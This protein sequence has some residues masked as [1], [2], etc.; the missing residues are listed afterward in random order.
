[1]SWIKDNKFLVGLGGGTLAGVAVLYFVGSSGAKN[2]DKALEDFTNASGEVESILRLPLSPTT[3][4]RDG[5]TKALDD[6][7][8]AVESIQTAFDA[9][10]PKEIK[11][12]SPEEFTNRIKAAN[13]EVRAGFDQAGSKVP[14][15]FLFC[16]FERYKDTLAPGNATGILDYQ[17]GGV[18]SVMLALAKSGI[19]E[20]RNV[21]RPVLP[22]EEG[23]E[24]KAGDSDVARPLPLEITFQGSE[25]SVRNFMSALSKLDG[26]YAVIRSIRVSNAKKDPPRTADAKFDKPAAAKP[27]AGA[28]G[29]VFGGGFVLPGDEPAAPAP[30]P[31][32]TP[33]PAPAPKADSSRILAQVLG[34]EDVQVFIRLDLLQF[35]PA[36]KLP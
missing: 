14:D 18:K 29:D 30:A 19:T 20:L 1:M 36:K 24:Y 9:Y 11:N 8:K 35:L 21:H 22:E 26:H 31:A 3:P 33:A 7:R 32:P 17:L 27:A 4:N 28:T 2:Y 25:K 10:R 23:R 13:S 12:I 6:Y 5:K 34:N 15:A 16:G